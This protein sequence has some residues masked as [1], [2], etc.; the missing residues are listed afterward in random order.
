MQDT[1]DLETDAYSVP[2]L[3]SLSIE[4]AY[5]SVMV[6]NAN[7][8]DGGPH[9]IYA[10]PAFCEMTG[11]SLS[12]LKGK[13]PK[14]LQGDKTDPVVI[15][16]LRQN[17]AKGEAFS[18]STVNYRKDDTPYVVE[19]NIT[20]V[21]NLAGDIVSFVSIQH[22]ITS[23]IAAMERK[24]EVDLVS[25]VAQ[26]G[27]FKTVVATGVVELSDSA[28][29]IFGF[30]KLSS[31]PIYLN[32][33]MSE[34]T[35][36]SRRK[37]SEMI[38]R[39]YETGEAGQEV[40]IVKPDSGGNTKKLLVTMELEYQADKPYAQVGVI[41]D[42]TRLSNVEDKL[43]SEVAKQ[44]QLF[45]IIAHEL[46]TPAS[47][48]Q[49]LVEDQKISDLEPHGG[50]ISE[51][52]DHLITVL[53]NMRIVTQPELAIESPEIEARIPDIVN[54][55]LFQLNR[56]LREADLRVRVDAD[57]MGGTACIVREQL[58]RQIT[59]NIV[60]NAVLH[61]EATWLNIRIRAKDQG[62]ALLFSLEF[63]DDGIG[64]AEEYR[65]GLFNAF[66]RGENDHDGAGLSLHVSQTYAKRFMDGDLGYR[67]GEKGGAVFTLST[68]LKKASV[69][70]ATTE[71]ASPGKDNENVLQG[72]TILYAEDSAVLRMMTVKMLEKAGA[73]VL[74]ATDGRE[75]IDLAH[76]EQFDM[77]LTDIFM[78]NEDGYALTTAVRNLGFEGP[79]VGVTAA[80]IGD[81]HERLINAGANSVLS[82]PLAIIDLKNEVAKQID[83]GKRDRLIFPPINSPAD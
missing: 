40:L 61:A 49:M 14:I 63:S 60:K 64:I 41:N 22:D 45:A 15:E 47:S 2:S 25:S 17:I 42:I 52:V 13:N 31:S 68:R 83:D 20:P 55:S 66:E 11:Y 28:Y 39:L 74:V 43:R 56:M 16:R 26:V 32:E 71:A 36:K 37:L 70:S 65:K 35:A 5:N 1:F 48:L 77:V 44:E 30:N 67:T 12:E 54:N 73:K 33:L 82:K 69:S 81:E 50:V 24:R 4:Q 21:R 10:N 72:L 34:F 38:D 57:Q 18:G 51:T 46:R 23:K 19:W 7:F 76:N 75:G 80:V 62:D 6:T 29:R 53:D 78:P 79:V 8:S 59:V 9:I 27:F 58:L 3:L